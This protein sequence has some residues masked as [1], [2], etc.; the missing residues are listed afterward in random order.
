[1]KNKLLFSSLLLPGAAATAAVVPQENP[2]II[3]LYIDDMGYSD[4]SCYGGSYTPTPNIDKLAGE[5]VRFTQYYSACPISSPSRAAITTG[6]YPTRWGITTFLDTRAA[7]AK[8]ESND[9]LDT[10]APSMSRALKA[11][12]YATGH[13]GKW[14]MGGGRDVNN[15]PSISDYGFDEYVS[16]YESPHPDPKLTSS[17]WIWANTDEVKRW[18][19][20]AYFVDKTLD[21][22]SKN[23]DRKPCFINLWPDDVHT[24][25]VYE[26]DGGNQ[27]ESPEHFTVVLAELDVQIGRLMQ[28]LKELGIDEN[29][30]VIFT[31]DNGPAPAFS[32]N[33]T[34]DLR[35]QKATLYEGGIRMPFI[36]RWP[37]VIAPGRVNTASVLCSVDLL[38]SL[39][40]ITGTPVPTG[41]PIDGKDMSQVLLGNAQTE[42]TEPLFWEFGKNLA[43]RIS[44]HIAVREGNWKLLVNANGSNVELYNMQ[45]DFLEKTNVASSYPDVVNRLQP[46]AIE[47]F[48][49]AFREYAGSSIR[50]ATGGDANKKGS[51]QLSE[52]SLCVDAGYFYF[53]NK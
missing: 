9:Y 13:F 44:P 37:G 25:W 32:G 30:L 2:N 29:T 24:P 52:D 26:N 48:Q 49:A 11:N 45:T 19:R 20:T 8:N 3:I 1:M 39:C 46:L 7:N 5:G 47:W 15:A 42:R 51:F 34:D 41:F 14:H 38:P 21:F 28:G 31:S 50:V 40:A 23:K 27:R 17:H 12:G 16:T 53:C 18:D 22:L 6:M 33:R 4:P 35:G 36:A 10:R 43:K